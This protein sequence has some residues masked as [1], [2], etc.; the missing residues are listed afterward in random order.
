M[1]KGESLGE[2]EHLVLLALLRLGERAY[3]LAVRR[4][5]A[6]RAEREVTIGAVYATLERLQAKGLVR[7]RQAEASDERGG[8]RR[9]YFKLTADGDAALEATHRALQRMAQD[10][11]L[12]LSS[13]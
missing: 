5:I 6:E 3:G 12:G 2:F 13:R 1:A 8:R 9:R 10:L 4:E 11:G 7:S